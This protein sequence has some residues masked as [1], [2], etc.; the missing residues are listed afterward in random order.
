MVCPVVRKLAIS[1]AA[2]VL[3]LM[4]N[5][6]VFFEWVGEICFN[7]DPYQCGISTTGRLLRMWVN[8]KET[9]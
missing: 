1:S 6:L 2:D 5:H 7:A 4:K 8:A 3:G 9:Y